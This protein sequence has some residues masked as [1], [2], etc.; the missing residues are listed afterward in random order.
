[1]NTE[2]TKTLANQAATAA[3]QR[4][5]Q[6]AIGRGLRFNAGKPMLS[7]IDSYAL[8]CL[9][10]V[11]T[12]GAKKYAAHNW[13]QGIPLSESLDSLLRHVNAFNSGEDIDPESGLP[14]MAHVMCNAMFI[15]W[16]HKHKPEMDDR[17]K[18]DTPKKP[19]TPPTIRQL[20]REDILEA[21]KKDAAILRGEAS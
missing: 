6:E 10:E 15:L 4:A 21:L 13:R 3:A 1:M 14:H 7:L 9:A 17:Y 11:L 16:T 2:K 19:Y 5:E 18:K 8:T 12:F 20:T